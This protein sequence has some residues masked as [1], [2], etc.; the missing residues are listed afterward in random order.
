MVSVGLRPD[1]AHR[2]S[3]GR[4]PPAAGGAAG[5]DVA[6]ASPALLPP[7]RAGGPATPPAAATAGAAV[8]GWLGEY[9]RHGSGSRD[10]DDRGRRGPGVLEVDELG[11][12]DTAGLL[13]LEEPSGVLRPSE[14]AR[15]RHSTRQG[16]RYEVREKG[17]RLRQP[18][19]SELPD[20][21]DERGQNGEGKRWPPAARA[22][23]PW[24]QGTGLRRGGP[25]RARGEGAVVVAWGTGSLPQRRLRGL[26]V[27]SHSRKGHARRGHVT[28]A[29][30]CGPC[31]RTSDLS[32][33]TPR[34]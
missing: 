28:D 24:T 8:A 5:S 14:D 33:T 23:R 13:E 19:R 16:L 2:T 32:G 30:G 3:P 17:R 7:A 21:E 29:R 31:P 11:E 9:E 34:R 20:G 22:L 15:H 27:R 25:G 12:W 1:M 26:T 6:P 4:P 18:G 10:H